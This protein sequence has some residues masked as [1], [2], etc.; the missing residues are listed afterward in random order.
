MM[1]PLATLLLA[2]VLAP[3]GILIL[4]AVMHRLLTR[5]GRHVTG[6]ATA[7]RAI[8][9]GFVMTLGAAVALGVLRWRGNLI[10]AA[11]TILYIGLT[12]G[13]MS[14]LYVNAINI[15]ETSLHTRTL[16]EILWA[17]SL[18]ADELYAKY[19]ADH[20]VRARVDRLASLGQIRAES[21]RYFL[22]RRSL[23][24]FAETVDR[25]RH[26]LGVPSPAILV[27][28]SRK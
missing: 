12:Y 16:L 7:M 20:M 22:A 2:L 3:A 5:G 19:N 23:L 15:A 14:L 13:A 6:H 25:W 11:A 21:S 27:A 9:L 10:E 17:G 28:Q 8:V 1:P 4:H 26:V 18:P 24:H